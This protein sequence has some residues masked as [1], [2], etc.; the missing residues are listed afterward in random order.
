MIENMDR[1][2]IQLCTTDAYLYFLYQLIL[3]PVQ[4]VSYKS[5]SVLQ[6]DSFSH[7]ISVVQLLQH[8]TSK[9]YQSSFISPHWYPLKHPLSHCS[10]SLQVQKLCCFC[11]IFEFP[12]KKPQYLLRWSITWLFFS[13]VFLFLRLLPANRAHGLCQKDLQSFL[14][15]TTSLNS[16]S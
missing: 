14:P 15:S 16:Y 10:G 6:L 7:S 8:L 4:A 3:R 13:D 12:A 1:S 11:V 5:S 9:S 2:Q